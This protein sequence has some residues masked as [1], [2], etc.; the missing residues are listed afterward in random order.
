MLPIRQ[1]LHVQARVV[2]AALLGLA[3]PRLA[4]EDVAAQLLPKG[5]LL[6]QVCLLA[7]AHAKHASVQSLQQGLP[8]RLVASCLCRMCIAGA[9]FMSVQRPS[10]C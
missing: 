1:P 3:A 6:C 4:R 8:R 9:C 2:C 5:L 7:R 10:A